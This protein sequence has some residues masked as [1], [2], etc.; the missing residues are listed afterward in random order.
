MQRGETGEEISDWTRGA[1]D[2]VVEEVEQLSRSTLWGL[3][4]I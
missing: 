2:E 1:V 4:E 3:D